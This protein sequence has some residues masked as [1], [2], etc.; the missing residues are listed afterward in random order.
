MFGSAAQVDSM[1]GCFA[2]RPPFVHGQHSAC[3]PAVTS[4]RSE[5]AGDPRSADG[6]KADVIESCM[7]R[8]GE[9]KKRHGSDAS[10][11]GESVSR[12]GVFWKRVK[13][14]LPARAFMRRKSV[15]SE[16]A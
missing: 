8:D 6:V 5:A 11:E 12:W 4:A 16:E 10:R 15:T 2:P 1:D 14:L 3:Q 13:R 9:R 7:G